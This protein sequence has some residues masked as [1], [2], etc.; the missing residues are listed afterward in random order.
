MSTTTTTTPPPHVVEESH[1][2]IRLYSDGTVVRSH[3]P[4]FS[5]PLIDNPA[6]TWTDVVYDATN[7][8]KLRLYKPTSIPNTTTKLPVFYFIHGGGFCLG[9]RTWSNFHNFCVRLCHELGVIVVA[10]DYRLAPETRLPAGIEDGVAAVEW[11]KGEAEKGAGDTWIGDVADF[12]QVFVC[13]DSAGGNIAHH[14]A[15]R[16]RSGWLGPKVRVRGFVML[17]PYFGGTERT[18]SE[19]EGRKDTFLNLENI[20]RYWRF[21]LPIGATRDHPL[22]NPFGPGSPSLEGVPLVPILV[23]MGEHDL[24]KDRVKDYSD[25]LKKLGNKVEY[26]EFEGEEHGFPTLRPDSK[27]LTELV[28]LIKKFIGENLDA[29]SVG[30]QT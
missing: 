11:L 7:D 20:D 4:A 26:V 27:T 14:V 10:P 15:V 28:E 9:S 23:V 1:G 5:F 2:V 30:E 6:V 19:A 12:R 18:R 16:A 24:L 25:R 22:A 8:L 13:G 29:S 17:A 21:S 3:N